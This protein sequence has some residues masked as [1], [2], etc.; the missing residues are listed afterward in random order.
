V[1]D[2]DAQS[3]VPRCPPVLRNLLAAG[4]GLLVRYYVPVLVVDDNLL[5]VRPDPRDFGLAFHFE[6][7]SMATAEEI[8]AFS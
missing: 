5:P 4:S 6:S 7:G 8:V 1:P 3:L 2:V